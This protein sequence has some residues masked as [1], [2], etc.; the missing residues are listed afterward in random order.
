MRRI[1]VLLWT[2]A[3]AHRAIRK[4]QVIAGQNNCGKS[5]LIDYF[6]K[7]I[8]AINEHGEVREEDNPLTQGDHPLNSLDSQSSPII[9]LCVNVETF[10]EVRLGVRKCRAKF[11][12]FIKYEKIRMIFLLRCGR[13]AICHWDAFNQVPGIHIGSSGMSVST[14]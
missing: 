7:V 5:V 1:S 12:A 13:L 10:K 8:G 3:C 14:M 9:S 2:R 11:P 6:I 4:V